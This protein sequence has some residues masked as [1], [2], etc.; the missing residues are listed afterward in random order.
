MKFWCSNF[1]NGPFVVSFVCLGEQ[2]RTVILG[3]YFVWKHFELVV[4]VEKHSQ[5]THGGDQNCT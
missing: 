1:I 2:S 3:L 4:A 5:N